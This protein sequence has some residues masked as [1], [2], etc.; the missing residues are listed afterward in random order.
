M[1]V[2]ALWKGTLLSGFFSYE[3]EVCVAW[4]GSVCMCVCACMNVHTP[5]LMEELWIPKNNVGANCRG[6]RLSSI[7]GTAAIN[8]ELDSLKQNHTKVVWLPDTLARLQRF[9]CWLEE[10]R[11]WISEPVA[12]FT[13]VWLPQYLSDP[14][15]TK[16]VQTSAPFPL[17]PSLPWQLSP[18]LLKPHSLFLQFPVLLSFQNSGPGKSAVALN[19]A[20]GF[21]AKVTVCTCC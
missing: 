4:G 19:C 11:P 6:S 1:L 14:F 9:Q 13:S 7:R 10:H 12:D 17:P 5:Q 15:Q 3:W 18:L 21:G 2:K 8:T 20:V 16:P